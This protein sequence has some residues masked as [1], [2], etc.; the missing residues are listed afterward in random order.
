MLDAQHAQTAEK[1]TT[2]YRE[3]EVARLLKAHRVIRLRL[4]AWQLTLSPLREPA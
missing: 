1:L 3:A 2:L 4:G